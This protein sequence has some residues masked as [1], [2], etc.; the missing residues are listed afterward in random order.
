MI[1][2]REDELIVTFPDVHPDARLRVEFQRTL[3]IPDD[4]RDYALPPGLGKFPVRHVDD[5]H[6][7]V[8]ESWLQRGG[9]MLPMYQSEAMW[10]N[11]G[12]DYVTGHGV[13]YPFA[14]KVAAGKVNAVSG[15]D[16]STI[17]SKRPQ[18]YVIAPEQPWLDGYC[19]EEGVIRQFV[20]MPL[21][22]GYTAE[23]QLTGRADHGGLQ[24][25]VYPMRREEFERRFP[26]GDRLRDEEI[27]GIFRLAE[28]TDRFCLGMG[29]A[30]GGRMRQQIF[31]DPYRLRDWDQDHSSRCF[32][33]IA[34]S[35][36][37]RSITGQN[38][39][40]VPPT[41]EDYTRR[42]LPWFEYYDDMATAVPGAGELQGLE[43]IAELGK[44]KGHVPLPENQPVDPD[45]IVELRRGLKNGQ[46]REG[47][48]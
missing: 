46:V 28:P 44:K 24:L 45:N 23:E 17:L 1:E 15:D 36:V 42:G 33:H 5:F 19:V 3:R 41:A 25:L 26:K 12:S 7:R 39:P 9:V 30:P 31:E 22:A 21:G 14:V 35:M 11:F 10:L 47:R 6:E 2:L 32:V 48:F 43:S 34:N 16:W 13:R 4:G 20:A 18:D 38:P 37:W 40:T 8:P 29:L 27:T